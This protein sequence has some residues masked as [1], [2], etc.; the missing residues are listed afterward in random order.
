MTYRCI[1]YPAFLTSGNGY[2]HNQN[3]LIRRIPVE[4]PIGDLKL[5]LCVPTKLGRGELVDVGW[6][7]GSGH[8]EDK[9]FN[10]VGPPISFYSCRDPILQSLDLT[11]FLIQQTSQSIQSPPK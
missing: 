7:R 8:L 9:M 3:R 1:K 4:S 2:L 5:A 6:H 10:P 11:D